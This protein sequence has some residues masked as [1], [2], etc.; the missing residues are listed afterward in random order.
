VENKNEKRQKKIYEEELKTE[1][2][3]YDFEENEFMKNQREK[4]Y[5]TVLGF[6]VNSDISLLVHYHPFTE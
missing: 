3:L 4:F 6:N 2:I 1:F 5:F